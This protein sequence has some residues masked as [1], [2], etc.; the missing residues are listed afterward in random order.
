MGG[1]A[2]VEHL[3]AGLGHDQ[4]GVPDRTYPQPCVAADPEQLRGRRLGTRHRRP[5]PDP[6]N[7][8]R[9]LQ[10]AA[11][12]GAMSTPTQRL[13]ELGLTLPPVAK[14]LAAYTPAITVGN[15]V[16]VSGQLPL[17]DGKLIAVSE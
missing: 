2:R 14:P 11:G 10:E 7:D 1:L 15:Q 6:R 8:G 4:M 5:R 12:G 17:R 9:V 13:A 3:M 16:W